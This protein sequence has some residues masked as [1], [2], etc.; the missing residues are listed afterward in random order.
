V[1]SEKKEKSDEL[2]AGETVVGWSKVRIEDIMNINS[3]QKSFPNTSF[4][5]LSAPRADRWHNSPK[6]TAGP[7][8]AK[9]K[10]HLKEG[11]IQFQNRS[12]RVGTSFCFTWLKSGQFY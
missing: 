12:N 4:S 9:I 2:R 11:E 1:V 6:E 3:D 7:V 10:Y 5:R 8:L